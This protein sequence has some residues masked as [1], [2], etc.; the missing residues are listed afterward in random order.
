MNLASAIQNRQVITFTY[1]GL[2]RVV[3]PATYG[4]TTTGKLTLRGCLIGGQSQRNSIPCW[5]LFTEAKMIDLKL[6]GSMFDTF[7]CEGYTRGDS[8]F[9][10]IVAEH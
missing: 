4:T 1:D 10:T 6:E 3:Q 8:A 7:D 9:A 2:P 5:E